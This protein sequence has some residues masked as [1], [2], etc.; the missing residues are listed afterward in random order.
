[1][2]MTDKDDHIYTEIRYR[3]DPEYNAIR[4]SAFG[5]DFYKFMEHRDLAEIRLPLNNPKAYEYLRWVNEHFAT[6]TNFLNFLI[7]ITCCG[8]KAVTAREHAIANAK[9]LLDHA[10]NIDNEGE[11]GMNAKMFL[12]S[13]AEAIQ[14]A[15]AYWSYPHWIEKGLAGCLLKWGTWE[16]N[17]KPGDELRY[18]PYEY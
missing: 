9:L 16:D 2:D 15:Y 5:M 17:E 3:D 13:A 4:Y 6:D 18:K 8:F 1:M 10:K 14:N 12:D 7:N 11:E